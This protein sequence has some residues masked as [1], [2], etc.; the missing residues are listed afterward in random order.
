MQERKSGSFVAATT[1][2]IY[3][4]PPEFLRKGRF[5]EIFFVDLP[6]APLRE[7]LFKNSLSKT[8]T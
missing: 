7:A 3:L 6:D 8:R 5:D 1:N 4:L 2:D